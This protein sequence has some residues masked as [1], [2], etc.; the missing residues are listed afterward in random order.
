MFFI[1]SDDF[2][3]EHGDVKAQEPE[4]FYS[5]ESV[6]N[7]I[8]I[9]N[10]VAFPSLRKGK[11]FKALLFVAT[12]VQES[13]EPGSVHEVPMSLFSGLLKFK[14]SSQDTASIFEDLEK[15]RLDW[16]SYNPKWKGFSHVVSSCR[17][18]SDADTIK[19]SFDPLFVEEYLDKKTPFKNIPIS[20]IMGFRSNYALKIYEIAYQYYDPKRRE[21]RTPGFTYEELRDLFNLKDGQ[22][23]NSGQ[24]FQKV[25]KNPLKEVDEVSDYKILLYNNKRRGIMRRYWFS[26]SLSPQARVDFAT[27]EKPNG[28]FMGDRNALEQK[29]K[30]E[31]EERAQ[32]FL[33]FW[34][35]EFKT[36]LKKK[37]TSAE[38]QTFVAPL[39]EEPPML[40]YFAE[41]WVLDN[42]IVASEDKKAEYRSL[43]EEVVEVG[44]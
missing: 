32:R 6:K 40:N 27:L 10:N 16:S 23:K 4:H 7:T 28:V 11:A 38:K 21:G 22:Y 44:V 42:Y 39:L 33:S 26:I 2:F 30:E 9:A 34:G 14:L 3:L 43:I 8:T 31:N 20:L 19:F 18:D 24:F 35:S 37:L 1:A 12:V 36:L 15:V 13:L 5:G 25:I 29:E 41:M 17:Y